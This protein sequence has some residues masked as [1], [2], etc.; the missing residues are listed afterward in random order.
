MFTKKEKSVQYLVH[1][2]SSRIIC[3]AIINQAEFT[4]L[5][6]ELLHVSFHAYVNIHAMKCVFSLQDT[7]ISCRSEEVW[8]CSPNHRAQSPMVLHLTAFVTF[9]LMW[10]D[11]MVK[12]T[13]KMTYLI[14]G[15]LTVSEGE[16]MTTMVGS[17]VAG[18]QAGVTSQLYL[19]AN[20]RQQVGGRERDCTWHGH[21]KPHR[22]LSTSF[23]QQ[24]H[25]S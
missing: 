21:W 22:L 17:M 16:S 11:A 12:A 7:A 5:S 18:G 10:S 24:S 20:I 3:K 25:I 4:S 15:L 2:T 13:Y 6:I 8:F 9:L 19:R 23:L 1:G 14:G